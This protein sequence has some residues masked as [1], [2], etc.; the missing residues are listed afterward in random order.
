MPNCTVCGNGEDK[1]REVYISSFDDQEYKLYE[2]SNCGLSWWEP[3]KSI[4]I[5]CKGEG[6]EVYESLHIGSKD[7]LSSQCFSFF[8]YFL[9]NYG[10]LFEVEGLRLIRLFLIK[11]LHF[12]FY[13]SFGRRQ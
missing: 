1:Y 7:E 3:L 13:A 9:K 11:G 8:R 6:S 12:Y 10:I 2:C 5:F 4:P